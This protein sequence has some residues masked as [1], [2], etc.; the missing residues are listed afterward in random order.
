ME[1]GYGADCSGTTEMNME[2][3]MVGKTDL[4]ET[5][6]LID[7]Y[8][9]RIGFHT[10]FN[11]TTIPDVKSSKKL[12]EEEQKRDEGEAILKRLSNGDYVVLLDERGEEMRSVEF[13]SWLQKRMAGSQKRLCFII[14]GPYGFSDAVYA[15]ADSRL[16]LSRMT[17]SH[18]LVRLFFVE[19]L[20]RSFSILTNQPYH[21][22]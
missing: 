20:Y 13:A 9:R 5:A 16:S 2:L 6:A 21:H 17:F 18:Q 14:G 1:F 10:R 7:L 22:E 15:R 12:S 8:T 19:Q 3:Y 4:P 11:I